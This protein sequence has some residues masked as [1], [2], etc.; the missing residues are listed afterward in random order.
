MGWVHRDFTC[1][2][3]SGA[4]KLAGRGANITRRGASARAADA[5]RSRLSLQ[6]T[7]QC[8]HIFT[9]CMIMQDTDG[10]LRLTKY[11]FKQGQWTVF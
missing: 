5:W 1:K 9:Y 11:I 10:G 6:N 4:G 8:M 7:I 2:V 3:V